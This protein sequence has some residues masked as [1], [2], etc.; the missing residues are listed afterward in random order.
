MEVTLRYT[1]GWKRKPNPKTYILTKVSNLI[2]DPFVLM[3]AITILDNAF[4]PNIR[5]VEDIFRTRKVEKL[6]V[7]I[8][9]ATKAFPGGVATSDIKALCYYTYLYY[10]Q[11]LGLAAGFMQILGAYI[12]RREVGEAVDAAFLGKPSSAALFKSATHISRYVDLYAPTKP[13][14]ADLSVVKI[15]PEI[16]RLRQLRDHLSKEVRQES[17]TLKNVEVE[18]TKLYRMY[19]N[20]ED[21]L[22]CTKARL[23]K[24]A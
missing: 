7:S 11:R 21:A 6:K 16:V 19:K 1:K 20:T 24:L 3:I 5:S 18:G 13:P 23:R 10:L 14:S 4:E 8:F 9:R 2:F 17:S 22:R 12:I 15:N